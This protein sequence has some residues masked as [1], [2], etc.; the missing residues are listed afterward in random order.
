[1]A[2]LLIITQN[3]N[4]LRNKLKR[5][6]C[7]NWFKN[8]KA[9]FIL[10][11]ETHWSIEMENIIRKEWRGL[12]FFSHGS[13]N[14][15][16]V[17]ILLKNK[18][19]VKIN[20]EYKDETG[21]V[22]IIELIVSQQKLIIVNIYAPNVHM[23]REIFFKS[24]Y[25][26]LLRKFDLSDLQTHLVICGDFNCV[27]NPK[28]DTYN[29]KSTYKTPN[30]LKY[31]MKKYCLIDIWRK[32]HKD[33]MQYTWRNKFLKI[34]SRIDFMLICKDLKKKM[35]KTDIRPVVSGDH[36]AVT[37]L[38]KVSDTKPGP[39]FWKFNTRLLTKYD[40]CDHVRKIILDMIKDKNESCMSWRETWELCKIK[41]KEFSVDYSKNMKSKDGNVK[42]LENKLKKLNDKLWENENDKASKVI[43][44]HEQISE[45]LE[46]IYKSKCK[47]AIIRSRVKWFEEG[48]KNTK[49][50]MSLE[51]RNL[52]K[53]T[54]MLLKNRKGKLIRTQQNIRKHVHDFYSTLYRAKLKTPDMHRY[55]HN[56]QIPK[57]TQ[58]L[59]DKCEGLLTE[60]ECYQV[61]MEFS[62][63]KS[64]GSDGLGIEFYQ[65]FWEDIK[66]VLVNSLN[67]GF[68][69]NEMSYTQRHAIIRLLHKKGDKTNL[70][71]WRPISLL[72][73]DYK[74]A[75]AVL[76]RRLQG[77]ISELIS[78]DQ[79]GYIK[80]RSLA[81]NI[82]MIEDLFYYV[83]NF[84]FKG[85]ALLSDF[86][87]AFDCLSW[88]FLKECLHLF[89]FKS[90]FC[91]WVS[92]LYSNISSSVNVNGWLT[93]K[94]SIT[95]GVRQG[96]P[97]SALLFILAAEILAIKIR[98]D[99]ELSGITMF[100]SVD[101]RIL[102]FAD[103]ATIFVN[104][105]HSLRKAIK[106]IEQFGV[107]SGLEL[108]KNKCSLV[109]M[110]NFA[111]NES[112]EG[113]SWSN[114][115]VKILGVYF[116]QNNDKV[117]EKNWSPKIAKIEN[118]IKVWKT[119]NLTVFGKITIIKAFLVSQI[120]YNAQMILMPANIVKKI[121]SL[122]FSFLWNCKKDKVKRKAV[123]MN[124]E[125][126]GLKMVNLD[127]LLR[128]FLLKW[129]LYYLS[130][131][132]S[133]WKS[134]IDGFFCKIGELSY[135]MNCNCRKI[136]MSNHLKTV[137]MPNYYKEI[138]LAW[139]DLKELIESKENKTYQSCHIKNEQL[140]FNSNI[141]GF[142][143]KVLFFKRWFD[144][145]IMKIK[146]LVKNS[147]FISLREVGNLFE[148]K[149]AFLFQ[150]YHV[151][152]HAIPRIWKHS[153]FGSYNTL[154]PANE[155]TLFDI[156][157][158]NM[159]IKSKSKFFYSMILN[160]STVKLKVEDKWKEISS[161]NQQ[162]NWKAIW[163][164]NLKIIKENK[165]AEFNFKFLH[166]LIPHRFNLFRW[167]LTNNPL[168][169]I[170][171]ELHDTVHLFL[172][173]KQSNLFWK[174]FND[175]VSRLYDIA[176]SCSI[177]TLISGYD[178]E[179]KHFVSL[180]VLIMYAKYAIY[181]TF[182]Y[183]ENNKVRFHELSIFNIFKRLVRN[184]LETEKHCKKKSLCVFTNTLIHKKATYFA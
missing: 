77:V 58:E 175:F 37:L 124:Y 121:N 102:Q 17:A 67:E 100:K 42:I 49:Y 118:L 5:Q 19:E 167:K 131:V 125:L 91:Q 180:N 39:G 65:Y 147:E 31:I 116:G 148:K 160:H 90:D 7:F 115:D 66:D 150:E 15:R 57:L 82:R 36:N 20:A 84:S 126:G 161:K 28:L 144:A 59:A 79:V 3:C 38:I 32:V 139:I 69:H 137:K 168:C 72:N 122:L 43:N 23:K 112:I 94:I 81:E 132:N 146:D 87:K 25:K 156:V 177:D 12:T 98:S 53:N 75:T 45:Q 85:I 107:Y 95:R 52:D 184:R 129:V 78:H 74:I 182:I 127:F 10:I 99:P 89:G 22:L 143:G 157:L 80:G 70:E 73:Y 8:Q 103:D 51:K 145:G 92:T 13:Q 105:I 24:L 104:D 110:K 60:Q 62:K 88:D 171:N 159:N 4:G 170:D 134:I 135:I 14:A 141:K 174:R 2:S 64:P 166:D 109:D 128:S 46:K 113:I 86:K 108:N 136:D 30:S 164:F 29:T 140:W 55:F 40:Y 21:R 6:I 83:R 101:V 93:E 165:I 130:S 50:F 133:K 178:L 61:V 162:E 142:D 63:N 117:I 172:N 54:I 169:E 181:V 56:L 18:C 119:R 16:G 111:V 96:C 154:K 138:I 41:I 173:C 71:N 114:S 48:E 153:N 9:D 152:I 76:A 47:G 26:T 179:N 149:H 11:Q 34:A 176:F 158:Q 106:H 163:K 68:E 120:I 33:K 97:L 27:L 155:K 123:C 183:A 44:E 151:L 1:M 35:I